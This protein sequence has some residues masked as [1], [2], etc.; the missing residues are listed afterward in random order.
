MKF[1]GKFLQ[2]FSRMLQTGFMEGDPD[3]A[4][5]PR[6]GR[7]GISGKLPCRMI[8]SPAATAPNPSGSNGHGPATETGS[9]KK[10]A[11]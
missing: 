3:G 8:T 4:F 9:S 5:R 1:P 6:I 2:R 7:S 11:G 10:T